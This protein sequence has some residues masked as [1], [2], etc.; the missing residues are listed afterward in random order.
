MAAGLLDIGAAFLVL[1]FAG[2]VATRVGLSVVPLYVVAGVLVGPNVAGEL[3][4]PYVPT[5]E[6]LTVFGELGI[7]LLLFFLGLEFSIDRLLAARTR[8][9]KA[10]L[11]DVG[12]NF[13]LGVGLGLL[14]GW[15]A[16]ESLL[17][18]GIVYISSSAIITKSLVD[19]GWVADPESEPVLGTLVFEDLVIAL[20]LAVVTPLVLGGGGFEATAGRV[21]VAIVVLLALA[22]VARAGTTVFDSLLDGVSGEAVTLRVL[23]VTVPVAGAAL[24]LG[25]SEAVAAFFVGVGFAGTGHVER[26][27]RLLTS[28]RDAFAAAF[29]LYIGLQTDPALIVEVALPLAVVVAVTAPAKLVSGFYGGRI[30]GLNDRR[31]ARVGA[32]LVARGEFSLIIAALATAGGL[33]E[34]VAALAVGYVLVMSLLG[35]M[36]MGQSAVVERVVLRVSERGEPSAA[37]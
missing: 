23:G 19:L 10:G 36:L 8:I 11:L 18:G 28:L 4:L 2:A 3:G 24:A 9:G 32:A 13:P 5:G 1:A 21:G 25:V 6:V 29:F 27:E 22:V 7:V 16:L 31:S 34:R 30:F 35:T 37:D 14:F 20:Y 15:S 33:P 12:V 17:L 26:I